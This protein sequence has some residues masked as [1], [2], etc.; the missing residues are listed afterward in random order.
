MVRCREDKDVQLCTSAWGH[1]FIL[2]GVLVRSFCVSPFPP[3]PSVQEKLRSGIILHGS[4][5]C[6]RRLKPLPQ[7]VLDDVRDR[8]ATIPPWLSCRQIRWNQAISCRNRGENT[9]KHALTRTARDDIVESTIS[10]TDGSRGL[11]HA[12]F[13]QCPLVLGRHRALT[14]ILP[15]TV[16]STFSLSPILDCS[17]CT[18]TILTTRSISLDLMVL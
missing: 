4:P 17:P 13:R 9:K 16:V 15:P 11:F 10:C 6:C 1:S 12:H 5:N 7:H 8:S 2:F 3:F 18:L 14:L